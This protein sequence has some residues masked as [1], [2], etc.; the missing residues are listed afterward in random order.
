MKDGKLWSENI[1]A[2][3]VVE[4]GKISIP[5]YCVDYEDNDIIDSEKCMNQL[6]K[7]ANCLTD[8]ISTNKQITLN[9]FKYNMEDMETTVDEKKLTLCYGND[10]NQWPDNSIN[11][12]DIKSPIYDN[13]LLLQ[14]YNNPN[15]RCKTLTKPN[16]VDNITTDDCKLRCDINENCTGFNINKNEN[17]NFTCS[18]YLAPI[19]SVYSKNAFG[20]Q[21]KLSN[22][23]KQDDPLFINQRIQNANGDYVEF[24][25]KGNLVMKKVSSP[26]I[27][28]FIDGLNSIA[29]KP[30][31]LIIN[32]KGELVIY[33]I[34]NYELHK[35]IPKLENVKRPSSKPFSLI[36]DNDGKLYILD[37]NDT[38][39]ILFD[40]FKKK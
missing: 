11:K 35:I 14:D 21:M 20:C 39:I 38:K 15:T 31:K 23:L 34:N 26:D 28:D 33:N 16:Q 40:A 17:N 2:I 27:E 25:S 10:K 8:Y 22:K 36:I 12:K 6:W 30:Y 3:E 37:G 7:N 4:I 1:Q 29:S 19:T 13:Y 24:N 18:T 32:N 5:N 9:E